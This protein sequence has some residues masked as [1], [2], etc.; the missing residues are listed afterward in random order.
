VLYV[1]DDVEGAFES[2]VGITENT[3]PAVISA[4]REESAVGKIT[5]FICSLDNVLVVDSSL[6]HLGEA[7]TRTFKPFVSKVLA[8][9]YL[10]VHSPRPV[11]RLLVHTCCFD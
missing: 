8:M 11:V 3:R 1:D 10:I 4:E 2:P 5:H 7:N 6:S 9:A